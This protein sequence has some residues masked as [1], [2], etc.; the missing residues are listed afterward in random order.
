MKDLIR[1]VG[2]M[3]V[4]CVLVFAMSA[5]KKEGT[6]ERM[7]KEADK[8]AQDAGKKAEEGA[9]KAGEA[10]GDAA[11]ELEGAGNR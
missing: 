6:A 2:M 1:T 9:A 4:A 7:G 5:C 11:R 3:A 10:A 8:A